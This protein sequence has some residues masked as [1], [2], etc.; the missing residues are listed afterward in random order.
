MLRSWI[1]VSC[2]RNSRVLFV[3]AANSRL[4][5]LPTVGLTLLHSWTKRHSRKDELVDATPNVKSCRFFFYVQPREWTLRTICTSARVSVPL[6][7]GVCD[8]SCAVNRRIWIT[9]SP[10]F[11]FDQVSFPM[12]L[13]V[14][15][16]G[17]LW[18]SLNIR[19]IFDCLYCLFLHLHTIFVWPLDMEGSI[20]FTNKILLFMFINWM[21]KKSYSAYLSPLGTLLQYICGDCYPIVLPHIIKAIPTLI[22]PF[23]CI[24]G[25][26]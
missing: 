12:L 22:L 2:Q 21:A 17:Y 1:K 9:N 10:K 11:P 23:D 8:W 6:C 3:L 7:V 26:H 25:C 13:F 18:L 24:S 20:A 19:R 5:L 14:L 16:R 4:V 15:C